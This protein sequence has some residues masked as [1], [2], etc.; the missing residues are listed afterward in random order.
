MV[1]RYILR[2][3]L[4]KTSY[5]VWIQNFLQTFLQIIFTLKE[6]RMIFKLK[7]DSPSSGAHWMHAR[8]LFYF[9]EWNRFLTSTSSFLIYSLLAQIVNLN[10]AKLFKNEY[11]FKLTEVITSLN[12]IFFVYNQNIWFIRW[13]G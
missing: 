2:N 3:T 6:L 9:D 7:P 10:V 11:Y 5:N 4:I 8:K 1:L 13:T 12:S